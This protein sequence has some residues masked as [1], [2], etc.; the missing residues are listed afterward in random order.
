M[1]IWQMRYSIPIGK[2]LLVYVLQSL[3]TLPQANR[4]CLCHEVFEFDRCPAGRSRNRAGA[5][6]RTF[7]SCGRMYPMRCLRNTLPLWGRCEIQYAAGKGSFWL[8][9][10][11]FAVIVS[12]DIKSFL[13]I[14]Q[15]SYLRKAVKLA[16]R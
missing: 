16:K 4:H 7:P 10:F 14:Y 8:L 5:L 2:T 9:M 6:R 1:H 12:D 3:R 13:S 15:T 11:T